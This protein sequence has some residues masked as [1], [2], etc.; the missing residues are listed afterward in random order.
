MKRGLLGYLVRDFLLAQGKELGATGQAVHR[1]SWQS[2]LSARAPL[3]IVTLVLSEQI[4]RG[5]LQ[6]SSEAGTDVPP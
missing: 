4:A 6:P 5:D 3:R 1:L 2:W